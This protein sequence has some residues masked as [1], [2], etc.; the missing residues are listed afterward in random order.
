MGSTLK[1]RF[2]DDLQFYTKFNLPIL[3]YQSQ[4]WGMEL[5]C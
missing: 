1:D 4:T 3:T 2:V 5:T